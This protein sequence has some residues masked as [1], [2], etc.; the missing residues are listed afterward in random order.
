MAG[1]VAQEMK[2]MPS[3]PPVQNEPLQATL[4]NGDMSNGVGRCVG[5]GACVVWVWVS[6]FVG[7][8][9]HVDVWVR[10]CMRACVG[11]GVHA[12]MCG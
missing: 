12:C 11:E 3:T 2:K 9:V 7:M 6:M 5:G 4:V 10:V 8:Y 1:P